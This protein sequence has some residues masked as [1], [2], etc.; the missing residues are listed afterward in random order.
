MARTKKQSSALR[1][2]FRALGRGELLMSL[3]LDKYFL[4]IIY[5][6]LLAWLSIWLSLKVDNTL[7]KVQRGKQALT[8]IKIYYT[9]KAVELESLN[10]LSTMEK[11]LEESGS[12]L[13]LPEQPATIIRNQ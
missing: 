2:T 5:T 13:V 8:D 12:P 11:M 10:R 3:H 1:R 9:Q 4:H 7:V 6:F